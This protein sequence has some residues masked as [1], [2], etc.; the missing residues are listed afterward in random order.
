MQTSA[1]R[2]NFGAPSISD[3]NICGWNFSL[4][5]CFMD[6]LTAVFH[7]S[8]LFPRWRSHAAHPAVNVIPAAAG[9]A[10]LRGT[11]T[12]VTQIRA[13]IKNLEL[14][15]HRTVDELMKCRLSLFDRANAPWA[16]RKSCF[17]SAGKTKSLPSRW[18]LQS[19]QGRGVGTLPAGGPTVVCWNAPGI[20][21]MPHKRSII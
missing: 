9:T 3:A 1:H 10:N 12:S 2:L 8:D 17:P 7:S 13:H 21:L 11:L 16:L 18:R 5:Q 14:I 6:A 4:S 20:S 15:A 19:T